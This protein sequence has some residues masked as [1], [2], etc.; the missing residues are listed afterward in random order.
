MVPRSKNRP[1]VPIIPS[2]FI[3]AVS[4]TAISCAWRRSLALG[5]PLA[6]VLVRERMRQ[7]GAENK[8]ESLLWFKLKLGDLFLASVFLLPPRTAY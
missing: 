7:F 3:S 2:S 6:S 1:V 4:I 8:P 5:V